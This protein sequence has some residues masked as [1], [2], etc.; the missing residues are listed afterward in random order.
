MD[1]ISCIRKLDYLEIIIK[2]SFTKTLQQFTDNFLCQAVVY[3]QLRVVVMKNQVQILAGMLL[4][5]MGFAGCGCC[6]SFPAFGFGPL[7]L[8]RV[9]YI[10]LYTHP[11]SCEWC[12]PELM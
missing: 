1:E 11:Y 9:D 10:G 5:C 8:N 3:W 12:W 2:Y 6:C 4:P 7:L